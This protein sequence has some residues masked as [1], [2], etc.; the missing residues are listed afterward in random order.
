[1]LC[2]HGH[3]AKTAAALLAHGNRI[4][5]AI[6]IFFLKK[7]KRAVISDGCMHKRIGQEKQAITKQK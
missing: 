4:I 7:N 6:Y 3:A 2:M 5:T 1:M